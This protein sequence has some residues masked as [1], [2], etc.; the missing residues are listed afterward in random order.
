MEIPTK[1]LKNGFSMPVFGIGTWLMG[2]DT[3][4]REGND[5]EA[6]LLG[7]KNALDAGVTHIDT[8]ERYAGG[9]AEELVGEVIKN[10]DRKKLFIVSK[11]WKTN[12]SYDDVLKALDGSLRRLS[13]NYLDLY[14]I[15]MPN[16][17]IPLKETMRAF[18]RAKDEGLIK[19]IGISDF[20]KEHMEEA[21]SLSS[22]KIVATQVH[23]NLIFREPE[24]KGVIDYC[25]ENDVM[26]IAWRPVQ[27][28]TLTQPGTPI[29]DAMC[30]KYDKK[31][32]SQIAINWLIS[33]KNIVTLSKMR[34]RE[35]LEEN[36]GA[37]GW[38]MDE[39]DV[40]KLRRDF[41]GQRNISDAVPLQ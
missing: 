33:Q 32:P 7:L 39:K 20:T 12:L 13:T 11:V 25:M 22:H 38:Q 40:E 24:R 9:H 23:Y 35:H 36:L 16:P 28:G 5:D 14:L 17:H 3:Q 2:G 34:N 26:C 1:T 30:E 37:V 27:K 15:H 18:D 8:A 21:Q 10:Y 6:D 41:P 31:T 19:E 4:R 29:M